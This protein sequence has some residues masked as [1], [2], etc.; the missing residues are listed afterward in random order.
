[1]CHDGA[2]G[3]DCAEGLPPLDWPQPE[4]FSIYV[5]ELPHEIS[6]VPWARRAP[7]CRAEMTRRDDAEMTPR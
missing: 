4:G 6:I 3:I 2:F 7:R 5:Y 1:M